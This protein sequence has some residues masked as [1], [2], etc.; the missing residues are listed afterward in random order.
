MNTID[1]RAEDTLAVLCPTCDASA[2]EPC[3][4]SDGGLRYTTHGGRLPNAIEAIE[5][6]QTDVT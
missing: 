3:R 1:S 2:S 5:I 6:V 4:F